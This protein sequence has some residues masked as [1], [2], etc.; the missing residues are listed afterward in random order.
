MYAV[1][2]QYFWK[3]HFTDVCGPLI[4]NTSVAYYWRCAF[5]KVGPTIEYCLLAVILLQ[6]TKFC[7][8]CEEEQ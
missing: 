5:M 6:P 4:S 1:L 8:A 7:E 3:G 2:S